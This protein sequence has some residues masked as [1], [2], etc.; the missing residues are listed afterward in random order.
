MSRN[1]PYS[2]AERVA[3]NLY[4]IVAEYIYKNID[5]ERLRGVQI[6]STRMT[7]DLGIARIY[8]Y[9]DGGKDKKDAAK[10]AFEEIKPEIRYNVGK[11]LI[12]RTVPKLEFHM[13]DGVENAERIETI[14]NTLKH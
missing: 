5:D 6:T 13:D 2:R 1:L 7:N 12:L 8:F 3:K 9:I 4:Q 14:L 11:E 10:A